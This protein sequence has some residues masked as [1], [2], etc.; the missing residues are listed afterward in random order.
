ML[1]HFTVFIW[2]V[3]IRPLHKLQY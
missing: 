2:C 3:R 1:K